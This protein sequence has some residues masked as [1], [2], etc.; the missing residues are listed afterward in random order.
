VDEGSAR[1]GIPA[2]FDLLDDRAHGVVR[3]L[4]ALFPDV[5]RRRGGRLER[6]GD[7]ARARERQAAENERSAQACVRVGERR[8][9]R[10]ESGAGARRSPPSRLLGVPPTSLRVGANTERHARFRTSAAFLEMQ[11]HRSVR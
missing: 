1:S 6:L 4:M 11:W 3:E 2:Q 8:E 7:E 10:D 9:T 5:V